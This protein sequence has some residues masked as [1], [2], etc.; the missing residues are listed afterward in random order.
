MSKHGHAELPSR[1]NRAKGSNADAAF[2]LLRQ[3][4]IGL[5]CATSLAACGGRSDKADATVQA[6]PAAKAEATAGAKDTGN[7]DAK[8]E[9]TPAKEESKARVAASV[10][11]VKSEAFTE[12]IDASG[13]VSARTGHLATL[14]APAPARISSVNVA[15]GSRV[16][17]GDKLVSF[18]TTSF[19]AA[20]ASADATLAAAEQSA[21]RAR[22]LV[23]AGVS[24]RKDAELAAAELA[25]AKSVSVNAHRALQ[26]ATLQSPI[27]GVV[28]KLTATLGAN[29]DVGQILVEVADTRAL[30][31][32]LVLSPAL[33]AKVHAGQSVVFRDR[34]AADA[35]GVADGKVADVSAVVDSNSRG[36]VVRVALGAQKRTLRIGES[37]YGQI[38]AETHSNAVVISDEALVPTGEG[39]QVF[40][41][42]AD[43]KAHVRP[44]AIGARVGHRVWVREGL[45]AGESIVTAGA[46]GMDDGATVVTKKAPQL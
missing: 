17:A 40:V 34:A 27:D 31:V 18:E 23:D 30:D 2:E 35:E 14:S 12:T 3:F 13:I 8:G 22:R 42:D 28:T 45:K 16:K 19:E 21:A 37:V 6:K 44:I 29:A 39:F 20:V 5:A 4:A 32:Q 43:G 10:A 41:V 38:T 1:A 7:A 24:P 33:A 26:L 11:T 46:Y 15:I 36:V 9:Q 25:A